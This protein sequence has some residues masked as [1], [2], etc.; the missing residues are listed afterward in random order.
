MKKTMLIGILFLSIIFLVSCSKSPQEKIVGEWIN[1]EEGIGYLITADGN[2][3][4]I[5]DREV[6]GNEGTWELNDE[7]PLVLKILEDGELLI[8]LNTTF[9]N[10]DEVEFEGEN[11]EKILFKRKK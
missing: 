3:K 5:K 6:T 7:E 11:G 2:V 8:A 1:D 9:I 4:E 10:D